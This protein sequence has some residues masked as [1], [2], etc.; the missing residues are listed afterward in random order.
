MSYLGNLHPNAYGLIKDNKTF[1]QKELLQWISSQVDNATTYT[2]TGGTFNPNTGS[3]TLTIGNHNLSQGNYITL[4]EESITFTC[5]LDS[6]SSS[7]SYPRASGG[8]G[9]PDPAYNTPVKIT[10]TTATTITVNVGTSSDTSV[11]TFTGALDDAVGS[12]WLGYTYNTAKCER[13]A[14][15]V[16]DAYLYDLRY[17]GNS[18]TDYTVRKYWDNGVAQVDGNRVAEELGHAFLRDLITD[19]VLLNEEYPALQTLYPQIIN[20]SVIAEGTASSIIDT[21][22]DT[23][24]NVILNGIDSL[25]TFVDTGVGYIKVQGKYDTGD[26][27]I[28]TNTDQN[29][30]IYTF[31]NPEAGANVTFEYESDKDFPK[32]LQVT[33]TVTTLELNYDTST[34]S[35][36]DQL[37]IFADDK[38]L[39][40]R[41]YDFGTDAIERMRIAPPLSM[42]DADFEYGL[43][44]TKWSAI[45]TLRG[46]P[47]VYEVPGTEAS[48]QSV[49]TDASAGTQGVGA[50]LITVVTNGAHGYSIGGAI[51]IKGLN[52]GIPGAARA[53]GSFIVVDVLNLN[54][55]TYYAKSKV[56]TTSGQELVTTYTQLREAKF[57]TGASIGEPTF[58]IES[59]GSSGVMTP[60]LTVPTGADIIPFNG[61]R[62]EIGAPLVGPNIPLGSQVTGVV[63]NGGAITTLITTQDT[64]TGS[65]SLVVDSISNVDV[66]AAL[67]RGDGTAVTVIG[68]T[69]SNTVNLSGATVADF[70]GNQVTYSNVEGTN[71]TSPGFG[72]RFTISRSGGVYT[73]GG[74]TNVGQDY[75]VGDNLTVSGNDLGG[76]SP[77]NDCIIRLLTVGSGGTVDTYTVEGT[78]FDGT[79]N[80]TGITGQYNYGNGS[81]AV[82]D[83]TYLN[84]VYS[85]TSVSPTY[86]NVPSTN[87]YGNGTGALF[88]VTVLNNSYSVSLDPGTNSGYQESEIIKI[89]GTNLGGLS[90]D[91]DLYVKV[92][93]V[94]SAGEILT[95]TVD[96]VG[97]DAF[98]SYPNPA[99]VYAGAGIGISFNI[100]QSGSTYSANFSITGSGFVAG[101][102]LTISGTDLGGQSPANDCTITIQTVDTGGEILTWSVAGTALNRHEYANQSGENIIGTSATFDV[103]VNQNGTYSVALNSGGTDYATGNSLTIDGSLI[104]GATFT[105]DITVSVTGINTDS[106]TLIDAIT[107][108]TFSGTAT[109]PTSGYVVNDRLLISG[110]ALGGATPDN[111]LIITV[112]SVG[113]DGDITGSTISGT[114]PDASAEYF[115]Q[116]GTTSGSGTD[117]TFNV[118]RVGTT[119]TA[120]LVTIGTGYLP[121]DTI[122]ITG[123]NLGGTTPANNCTITVQTVDTG[124]EILTFTVSGTANNEDLTTGLNQPAGNVTGSGAS[125]DVSLSGG[126]Y[127][128]VLNSAGQEYGPDQEILFTGDTL[129]G[130]TPTNDLIVTIS[131]IASNGGI[132]TFTDSGTAATDSGTFVD[133]GSQNTPSNGAGASFDIFRNNTTYNVT[134]N[135]AGT[136]YAVGNRILIQ[137]TD[138][139]GIPIVND[140]LIRITEVDTGTGIVAFTTEGTGASGTDI[141]LL[142]AATMSEVTTGELTPVDSISFSAL[143]TIGVTFQNAHGLVP[144]SAFLVSVSTDDGLNNHT[145]AG[146]SYIATAVPSA[147]TLTY[148]ARAA[149]AIDVASG[150]IQADIYPR[151]DSFF[152]HRPF[153]GGVQLGTGGPQ[154]GAQAIR[155]SKKYIRYQSGKGIMYTTGALF[156]PSYGLQSVI[157][158]GVEIGSTITCVCDDNDHGLQ[159]GG[160]IRLIG[161]ETPGFNSDYTVTDIV[162]ERTF[163]VLANKRLGATEAVLTF[164]SQV[165]TKNWNGATVRSGIFDDQNG[166]FWEYD[167]TYLSVVQRTS[168]KQIAGTIEIDPDTNICIGTNTRFRDQLKAGD[169]I[170]IRGMTH[171]VSTINDQDEMTINPDFRGVNTVSGVKV[172]LITDKKVRQ[173]DF[174][175][176]RL[177]GTGESGYNLD[178]AKMQMIGIQ[179][180]WY[181]AGF[182]DYMV[183]GADGNFVYAHRMRN[184]NVN[185]EAYMRSGNLPVRY[186]VTNEGATA[187]LAADMTDAQTTLT[188]DNAEFF[189]PEGGIVYIDNELISY[190]SVSGNQLLDL[191]R[192]ASLVNFNAG[193]QRTYTAGPA[194]THT[195]RT[196]VVLVS[197]TITPL[198]SHWGSSFI[199]DGN[200][201]EDRGYIFSYQESLEI[202]TT[203]QTSFLIRLAPSVSNAIVG[204]LG[205]REL[206]NRAQLLLQGI[207]VTSDSDTTGGSIVVEG[208][209]NPQNYP[210][211][212]ENI[213]WTELGSLAQGG[214]PS[215]AQTAAGSSVN[216]STGTTTTTSTATIA[217][218][219]T[220]QLDSGIY[221]SRNDRNFVYVNA[222]DYRNTFGSNNLSFVQGRQITGAGIPS[223]TVITGGQIN[224]NNNYGYF[225]IS[226]NTTGNINANTNNAFTITFNTQTQNRNFA[227]F[228][229]TSFNASGAGAGTIV[230]SSNNATIPDNTVINSVNL[231]TWAG[232]NYYEVTFNNTYS[233]TLT[234]GNIVTFEF[235]EPPYAQPGETV[236]SF[237][238][239]TGERSA[240]S[241]E[242]MKELT[243]TTLGGRGVFPNG[244]DVLAINVYKTAGSAVNGNVI[245]RWGEAQA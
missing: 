7:H 72:A 198:I 18:K 171:V 93:T 232:T 59:Q 154:H 120:G 244:P 38:E 238:S 8:S 164:D 121:T 36:T 203:K 52:T 60:A 96:G 106:T 91:N 182:I 216:W 230:Q 213:T 206:L 117:A 212:P 109:T 119:Y 162:D 240:L 129:F 103:T 47:S 4:A 67:D 200:F 97:A 179:Y 19:Y 89:S 188:L 102:T 217:S 190:G 94:D 2:P 58:S 185:T 181:G 131:T 12:P 50:S 61:D 128:V 82:F 114:A 40:V 107:N 54:T 178:P 32:F 35:S 86:T 155:Q 186:E 88:N 170:V 141:D 64:A 57:Y 209:L 136:G 53:E 34:H 87:N 147:T 24:I 176:D 45:A 224:N 168:T 202:G 92:A 124:G 77:V 172:C 151:P 214:Q 51:T 228:D 191:N 148:Q 46:Y 23:V 30:V 62:P 5:A 207:E 66:G 183:R 112:T 165:S 37:Q 20:E 15:Y 145:L 10:A 193:A 95:T 1:L 143:A 194:A 22:A 139:G 135:N 173:Q 84:N 123:N 3:L 226:N 229:P 110:N 43:Q 105:N 159:V 125:F 166:I 108:F 218:N 56:G 184:S 227:Y 152:I 169:R 243:N 219:I 208:I 9:N 25:P 199:T 195:A 210:E 122:T 174:N 48:V 180:S 233:G 76:I 245:V 187:K 158:D 201:D 133:V 137:G 6:D 150:A 79:G 41:P 157:A 127:T 223:G 142:S 163:R 126:V 55:F 144:G 31:S 222:G 100:D 118:Q 70:V 220:T 132:L 14:G 130:Q 221:R 197:N 156:A 39:R 225:F 161:I 11:H 78:A 26:L 234:S 235:S 242:S 211:N 113:Q 65:T 16:I 98:Q 111:D 69:G 73:V 104:G 241:L 237:I 177:D 75:E 68:T 63:G 21:L 13:D 239:A 101:E 231:R 44:P 83:V 196:G 140:L 149:G 167:G 236:F 85:A 215:F 49:E 80:F 204:D 99:Y 115:N 189:P 27:L 116:S 42:L 205:D 74:V 138:L 192:E 71:D 175:L 153:D 160:V 28:I 90:P 29:E 17:G 146:G 33:D 134:Q 81:G